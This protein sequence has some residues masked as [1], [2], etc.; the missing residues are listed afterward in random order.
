[1]Q[2]PSQPPRSRS[3]SSRSAPPHKE[4]RCVT[5]HSEG[6]TMTRLQMSLLIARVKFEPESSSSHESSSSQGPFQ[7]F[8][9][10]FS[11]FRFHFDIFNCDSCFHN[12]AWDNDVPT[13]APGSIHYTPKVI[14]S[15]STRSRE[16]THNKG[17]DKQNISKTFEINFCQKPA[18]KEKI[19]VTI[20]LQCLK[21]I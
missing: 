4:E 13:A 15:L 21:G 3:V 1:M 20:S 5:R 8:L 7:F 11:F 19:E 12:C 6:E 10:S 9:F 2:P 17:Q 16:F 14:F 18:D